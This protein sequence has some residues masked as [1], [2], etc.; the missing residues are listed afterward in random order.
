VDLPEDQRAEA[1]AA[2]RA[3]LQSG[4]SGYHELIV[5]TDSIYLV[6]SQT[7][8]LLKWLHTE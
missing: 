3:I 1:K 6:K 8:W 4:D 2:E 5:Y 7:E